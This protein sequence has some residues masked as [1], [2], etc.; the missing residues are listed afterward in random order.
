MVSLLQSR[1]LSILDE[2]RAHH[3]LR[4]IN[5]Y[6]LSGYGYLLEE[7]HVDGI[8]SH[9]FR[10]GTSFDDLLSLYIFDRHLRLLVLD[11]IERIEVG[12][13][14]VLAYELS[15]KYDCGHWVM[16][17]SLFQ[18]TREF[19]H[20]DLLRT[21][22]RDTAFSAHEGTDRHNQRE[23]FIR[24]YYE[25]YDEPELPP[26]WMLVEVMTLGSWSK[27]YA[28]LRISKD[29]KMV[30]RVFDLSPSMLESWLHSLTCL[31]N[32]CAHHGQLYGRRLTFPPR[33]KP[34]WPELPRNA[35]A[36]FVAVMEYLLREMAPDTQWGP[37]VKQ[38][39]EDEPLVDPGLL[40]IQNPDFWE[41]EL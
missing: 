4:Y 14:T 5:Y 21:I 10:N 32:L 1:N 26:S 38:L 18:A 40:G 19:S 15:H 11:A 23:P 29:R 16:D 27:V 8:R 2:E 28:N 31:R 25:H 36:R 30:S 9:R 24:H 17:P 39:I 22:R 7:P 6:R 34:H 41:C 12:I 37:R 20:A 33:S 35:F 3:Y 13:R